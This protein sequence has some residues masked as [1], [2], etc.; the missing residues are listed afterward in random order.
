MPED[1]YRE[2]V[3]DQ[4]NDEAAEEALIGQQWN[5]ED[6]MARGQ[7]VYASHCATCHQTDGSGLAPAFPALS[8]SEFATGP[9]GKNIA[10][11]VN[12]SEGTAMQAWGGMLTPVDIGAVLTYIRNAFGNETGD[13]IQPQDVS[14]FEGDQPRVA[15]TALISAISRM[16]TTIWATSRKDL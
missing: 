12:G 7:Q 6:L 9:A 1:G 3:K 5:R 4:R 14:A 16:C 8:G 13:L 11:V 10:I 15:L 2:W